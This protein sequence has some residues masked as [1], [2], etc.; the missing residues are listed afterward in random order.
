MGQI[1]LLS[2]D[3]HWPIQLKKNATKS[4]SGTVR[5]NGSVAS[6]NIIFLSGDGMY[7]LGQTVSAADGTYSLPN[8]AY[9]TPILI[10]IPG[11]GSE[12]PVVHRVTPGP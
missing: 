7:I 9:N 8:L 12:E 6:R 3:V 11:Q 4:I 10:L 5:V 1:F 2:T